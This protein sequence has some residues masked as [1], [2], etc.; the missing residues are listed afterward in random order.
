MITARIDGLTLNIPETNKPRVVVIGAGFGGLNTVHKLSSKSFQIVL[1]D[2]H[3]YHTF[4]PLLYQVATAGLQPDAIAGPLRNAF[5]KKKDF[6]FRI[7]RALSI[8]TE[9]NTVSTIAGDL[10]YDYLVIGVGMKT[11]FFGNEQVEEYSLPLKT[12]PDALDFRSQLMQIM[13]WATMTKDEAIR[14]KMLTIVIGGGGPTGVEM[15]GAL[16]EL[17]KYVLPKDYPNVDFSKMKIYVVEGADRLLPPMSPKSSE[18]AKK[19]LE[20]MGVILKLKELVQS[21]DGKTVTLKSGEKIDAYT[22]IW[23]AGVTGDPIPGL[24]PEWIERGKILV[25]EHC[26]VKGSNNIYAIGDIAS[27][28]SDKYPKGLPGVAQ[29]AIQM[30]KYVGKNLSAFHNNQQVKPF[31]Y[32]DKGS[33][34]TIGRGKAVA[35]FPNGWSLGGRIAWWIW[36]FVHISFLISFRNKLLVF[37]NWIWN[38][39]TYDKGNRLIIRPYI[40]KNDKVTK[41]IFAL[42]ETGQ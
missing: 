32:F 37:T 34:A 28:K 23:S 7:L 17:R 41:E 20:K 22:M 30:G 35:D 12:I 14:E 10:H 24:K 29:P 33:L 13:E 38:Y 2:K 9:K 31:K 39:F 25:D 18:R 11:N 36:L 8:D 21:Y 16:A 6:H 26:K 42:N 27:F 4:Q 3:N 40:R 19:Y 5:D 15:A 1:L